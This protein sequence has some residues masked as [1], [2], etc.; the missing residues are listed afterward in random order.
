MFDIQAT[1]KLV[2]TYLA[3]SDKI[4][5]DRFSHFEDIEKT[6][7]AGPALSRTQLL[8]VKTAFLVE[9]HIPGFANEYLRL[10]PV[11]GSVAKSQAHFNRVISHFFLRWVSEEDRHAH[12]FEL[13]LRKTKQVNDAELT[14][15][16]LK[17]GIKG[18]RAFSEDPI[19]LFAYTT[20]QEKATAM[21]YQC[22]QRSVEDPLLKDILTKLVADETRH[23]K[24]FSDVLL[25][26][27]QSR[28]PKSWPLL[29]ET[30]EKFYMP[31]AHTMENY[32]RRS[33]VMMNEAKGYDWDAG[34]N[35][36]KG[37]MDKFRSLPSTQSDQR[38]QDF[39]K[40]TDSVQGIQPA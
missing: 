14:D 39:L 20:I 27:I 5:W 26:G 32:K 4:L 35:Y 38:W 34:L 9:D 23:A 28:G 12:A 2:N 16:M 29:Q 6:P 25:I 31:L 24:F 10:F 8:A 18:Y 40:L 22:L 7:W 15:E 3:S 13:Y 37:L 21:F 19:A 17:E 11:D 33:I 1:E 36:L 30:L